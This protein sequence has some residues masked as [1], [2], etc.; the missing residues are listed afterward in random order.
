[1]EKAAD[2][3]YELYGNRVRIRACGIC[4]QNDSILLVR[5][6]MSTLAGFFLSPPGGGIQFGEKV[7]DAVKREF[8]EETGLLVEVGELLFV[9][10]FIGPPLHAI[11][12]FFR[13]DSFEGILTL[14]DDPEFSKENQIIER[15]VFMTVE[16][17]KS[18]PEEAVHSL[19][20]KINSLGE[21][22]D[23]RGFL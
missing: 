3:L 22:Y 6:R 17:I 5:H 9:N 16:E 20:S 11:E 19:F 18:F 14:G 2:D 13:I 10:E 12:L 21:I 15:V 4:I 23:L 8:F 1:L 7:T